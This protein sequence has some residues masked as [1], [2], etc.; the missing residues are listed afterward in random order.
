MAKKDIPGQISFF[1]FQEPDVGAWIK[2]PGAVICGIMRPGYIGRKVCWN[3]STQSMTLW[4]VGIL[5]KLVPDVY[6]F[7]GIRKD[8]ERA[9]LYT[10]KKQR[11]SLLL[12]PGQ[13]LH[14]CLPWDHYPERMANIGWRGEEN[15][16][17]RKGEKNG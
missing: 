12:M 13:E 9:I 4:K 1:D 6:Y 3:Q 7:N 17:K 10:G 11:S 2:E 5:E 14:E 8:C 15:R 16:R